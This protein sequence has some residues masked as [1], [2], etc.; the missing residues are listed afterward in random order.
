M[1]GSSPKETL[2]FHH[3]PVMGEEVLE[4]IKILPKELLNE[5]LI[6]DATLGGGGHSYLIL[7]AYPNLKI[8]GLDQDPIAR[9]AAQEK[10]TPF[11]T[12]SKLYLTFGSI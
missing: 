12:A 3:I 1:P 5:G 2:D 4:A 11:R 10:L 9:K 8:I 7:K 6:I